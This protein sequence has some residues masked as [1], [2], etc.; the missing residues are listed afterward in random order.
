M[1]TTLFAKIFFL[2]FL[3]MSLIFVFFTYQ[4]TSLQKNAIFDSQKIKAKSIAQNIIISNSDAMVVDDEITLLES[5]QDFVKL[6]SE[7]KVFSIS[8]KNGMRIV[9]TKD[10][11]Q[12]LDYKDIPDKVIYIDQDYKIEKSTVFEEEVFLYNFPVYFTQIL[13]GDFRIELDLKEYENQLNQLYKNSILLGVFLFI[14]SILISYFIAKMIAKPIV[15]L[16]AISEEISNGDLSKRVDIK[17]NDEI[18]QLAKSFNIM[19]SSLERSQKKLRESHNELEERVK[20]RTKELNEL[21]EG[22]EKRVSSEI[23]KRQEQEQLLIQQSKLAAMGEMIGN[24]AHQWRQ[25]LNAL[26]LVMQNIQFSYEMDELDDEFMEKSVKKVNLLTN[27]M[28]KTIDDF[29]NFFKPNKERQSF[30]LNSLV[31]KTLELIESAFQHNNIKIQK[32]THGEI[33]VF[34]FENEY[35]QTLMNI[36]NNA[37]DAFKE[38]KIKDA[39]IVISVYEETEYGVV[40]IEDNAGGISED[41]LEKIFEPY[42]TTKE[43]GKG[44]GIGLYMSK[45]IIEQNMNGKLMVSNE[46]DGAKFIVKIPLYKEL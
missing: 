7:I 41:I 36:L 22:L 43:E 42:F 14:A 21:N 15:S 31:D 1:K 35:S 34:G 13:W 25:P 27:N 37:K 45:I 26:G 20:Q 38:N 40:S 46:L 28:S 12:L 30:V 32:D 16:N 39:N 9:V 11:W 3:T 8:R 6:N 24:I 17:T 19:V 18:G 5:V 33:K 44:T 10:N 23:N 29:R 4:F 2:I